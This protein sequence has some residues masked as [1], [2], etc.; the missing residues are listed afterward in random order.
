MLALRS[1]LFNL[2]FYAQTAVLLVLYLPTLVMPR[3]VLFAGVRLWARSNLVLLRLV[4]GTR[5]RVR[6]AIPPGGVLVASKHQSAWETF[7]F[8]LLFPD[9]CF[10]LKRELLRVPIFGWL[11]RKGGMIALDREAGASAMRALRAAS[12]AAM[13]ERRQLVIFPEGTRRMPGAEPAY[14]G[15]VALLYSDLGVPCV[16]VALNSGLCWPARGFLRRPG[17][18]TIDVLDPIPPGLP[19]AAFLERL[20]DT[21][22]GASNRLLAAGPA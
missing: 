20:Q 7:V 9:P 8:C 12:R 3:P 22:E 4:T 19:R 13:A 6:G 11:L 17:T 10:V 1:T 14:K 5:W 21:I 16:P 18:I 15:G 2:L